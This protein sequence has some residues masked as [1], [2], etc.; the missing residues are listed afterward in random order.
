MGAAFIAGKT[1][2]FI[3]DDSFYCVKYISAFA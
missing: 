1:M 3:D 2:N